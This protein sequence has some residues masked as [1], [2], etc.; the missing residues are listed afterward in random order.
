M[1]RSVNDGKESLR[2]LKCRSV[3]VLDSLEFEGSWVCHDTW[4][5]VLAEIE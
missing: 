3:K 1:R 2:P 5:Q 4:A